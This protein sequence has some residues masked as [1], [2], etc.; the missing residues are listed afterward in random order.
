M[1]AY[2]RSK[3]L[4]NLLLDED[5]REVVIHR[6]GAMRYVISTAIGLGIPVFALSSAL[7]YF[8]SLRTAQLPANLIQAQR[9]YFGAHTYQRVDME[10]VFHTNWQTEA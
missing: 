4:T 7:A 5:I 10:G 1:R 8:D 3:K 2:D 6:Q 9:D